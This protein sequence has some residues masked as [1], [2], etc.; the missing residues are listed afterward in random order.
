MSYYLSDCPVNRPIL[1]VV[2][3][4]SASKVTT[5]FT[6]KDLHHLHVDICHW[7]DIGYHYLVRLDGT[8]QNGRDVDIIGAH[9][10][11]YNLHSIGIAYVGGLNNS[12]KA[13]DTRTENQKAALL[14]L[15]RDLR[16][17]Y[18]R[19]LIKGHRDYSPDKN[20]NGV[21]EPSE[22][23]KECPCFDARQEYAKL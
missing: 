1:Y 7:S 6:L 21:V 20:G 13:T 12:G 8:I 11:G 5:N 14:N 3:H 9:V 18:P 16:E 4:C 22:W 23:M 15:L 10:E 19:A 17:L 2:V